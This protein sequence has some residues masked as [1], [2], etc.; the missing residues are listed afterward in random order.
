MLTRREFGRTLGAGGLVLVTS[1]GTVLIEGCNAGSVFTDIEAWI[2]T[3]EK[4]FAGIVSILGPFLPP[5]STAIVALVNASFDTLAGVIAEYEAAP[6]AQ[7]ATLIGKIEVALQ[8]IAGNIQTFLSAFNV[9]GN[10]IVAVVI[11]LA[12]VLLAAIAGF[13]NAMPVTGARTRVMRTT[14]TFGGVTAQVVPKLMTRKQFVAAYDA[15][16]D[17]NGQSQVDLQ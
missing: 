7:K 17:S 5:G 10:P 1:G 6:A 12:Q 13:L 11:G 16:A 15:V 2:P 8:A 9:T 4:A 3:A 14:V